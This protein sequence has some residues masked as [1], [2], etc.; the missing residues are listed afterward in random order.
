[1][2]TT[3]QATSVF[4]DAA[5]GASTPRA[6]IWLMRQAGRYLPEYRAL[7]E[8]HSFWEM[9]RT[10]EIAAEVTVQP[11]RRF[12]LDAAIIFSDIM[13]PLPPMGV[14]VDFA[15]GP[16]IRAPVRTAEDVARLAV[17][18]GDELAPFVG[19]AIRL[20][21]EQSPVP[22]IGFAGAPLTVAGYAVQGAGSAD[23]AEF[24]SWLRREPL[25]AHALLDKLAAVTAAYLREQIA[26]GA[27]AVQLFDSWA[28]IHDRRVYATFGMP[29]ARRVLDEL[30]DTGVPRIYLAVG[31]SHLYPQIARLPAEVISVDWRQPL[32]VSRAAL[33]GKALQGNLD[34]T[35]MLTDR[36]TVLAAGRQVLR[37]GLG[38]A[39]IFNLGH[40]VLPGTPPDNVARLVD[41][42]HEFPRA[43]ESAGDEDGEDGER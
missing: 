38:G 11:L 41:L 7:K 31:A 4:L 25:A 42:V 24:R 12:P 8:R 29:Y 14:P 3:E 39:H 5:R 22:V 16:V 9:C 37:D 20:V 23:Y 32:D 40:G 1:M 28:G 17:P 10:P 36:E 21:R 26:A 43:T 6:P 13:T 15:P 19:E 34:P 33:P 18:P 2:T 27:G 30:A 35:V